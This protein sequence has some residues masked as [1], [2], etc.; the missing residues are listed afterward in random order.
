MRLIH[1]EDS[2]TKDE[3]LQLTLCDFI[4]GENERPRYGILSHRWREEEVLFTDMSSERSDTQAK[5]G[6]HKLEACCDIAFRYGLRYLWCDT[7]CIDKS[8]S[9]EL[10]EAINSMYEYYARADLCIAYLDDI[11]DDAHSDSYLNR[12]TWFTRGWTLQELIAPA[13]IEFFSQGWKPL[14]TKA[15]LSRQISVACGISVKVLTGTSLEGTYVSEKMSW[16][17]RRITTR[18]ED[19]AYSLMGL[20]SVH[21]PPLYGEGAESAFRRLQL[22]ILHTTTDHTLFAWD[23]DTATGDM[24]SVFSTYFKSE[25]FDIISLVSAQR[26]M[27]QAR[28]RLHISG[29]R[30]RL[31]DMEFHRT[32]S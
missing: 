4:G 32:K 17:A 12:A 19:Q 15:T 1:I 6:Y 2:H 31:E 7:C 10:S 23:S 18:P 22:E 11:E 16:A 13:H 28:W 21:M 14:G 25:E 9:A 8:S 27:L 20:F 30:G 26:L 29:L 3:H 5:R 24:V